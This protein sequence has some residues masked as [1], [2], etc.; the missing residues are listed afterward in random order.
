MDR[1]PNAD[2]AVIPIEK[3]T[4]Y[5]LDP[6]K[7]PNKAIAFERALGY[8]NSN[9]E[10]LKKNI[11]Q[12]LASFQAVKVGNK[13]FGEQYEVILNLLGANNK[14]AHVLTGWILDAQTGETR[15]TTLYITTKKVRE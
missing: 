2:K 1:L 9:A 5:A 8:T 13:G 4:K 15:L 12:N 6:V 10:Q 11:L 7:E 14:K 3:L